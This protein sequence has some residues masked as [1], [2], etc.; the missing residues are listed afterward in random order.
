VDRK[1][2]DIPHRHNVDIRNMMTTLL[3]SPI[4]SGSL[5]RD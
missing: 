1:D 3:I 4:D 2:G 5:N